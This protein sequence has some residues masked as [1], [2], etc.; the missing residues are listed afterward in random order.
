MTDPVCP[1]Y[2]ALYGHPDAGGY[3]EKHC[4]DHLT[5]VGFVPISPWHS[6]F[7]HPVHKLFLVVYVDDFKLSGPTG[8]IAIGW[9]LILR[10]I[11]AEEPH[12]LDHYL[13]CKHE[14]PTRVLPDTGATVR[15][16]EYNMEDFLKS[17]VERYREL[18]GATYMRAAATPFLAESGQPGFLLRGSR[19]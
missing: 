12:P 6:C 10:G 1:L 3:W 17:C 15:V 8:N 7:W 14:Q 4:E 19:S 5:S 18:T 9:E 11:S 16:M 13:G 2:M